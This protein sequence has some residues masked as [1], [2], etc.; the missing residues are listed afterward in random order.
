MFNEAIRM[1]DFDLNRFVSSPTIE[2]LNKCRKDDLI[3]VAE[4]F[5]I[6]VNRQQLKREIKRVMVKGLEELGVL[7]VD[8]VEQELLGADV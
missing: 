8:R 3:R 5:Q 2:Q 1:A 7:L 6:K 4:H